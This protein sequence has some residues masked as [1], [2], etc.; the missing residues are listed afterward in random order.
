VL[1]HYENPGARCDVA[2]GEAWR[3][4]PDEQMLVELTAWLSPAAVQFQ[5]G[6]LSG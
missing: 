2:L 5:F 3:V 6:K 4:R 1:V